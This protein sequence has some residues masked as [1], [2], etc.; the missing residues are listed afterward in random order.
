MKDQWNEWTPNKNSTESHKLIKVSRIIFFYF[1][2]MF[3]FAA[4]GYVPQSPRLEFLEEEE[5]EKKTDK[6]GNFWPW[7]WK[8]NFKLPYS[9]DVT[10]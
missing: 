2:N 4:E 1:W 8:K 9:E 5:E 3:F 10:K 6:P 7:S